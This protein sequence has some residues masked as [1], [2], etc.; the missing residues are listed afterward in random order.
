MDRV[1]AG[2]LA[3]FEDV[4]RHPG[5][6]IREVTDRTGLAQSL[7]SRIV[8]AAAAAG[9]L[10]VTTDDRDR[11]RVR[12]ELSSTASAA[13]LQ[14]ADEPLDSALEQNTPHLTDQERAALH[15]HLAAAAE[16]LSRGAR[17]N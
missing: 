3:V 1:N 15:R 2:Q 9:A 8:G 4:A 16:L 5:A 7:V 13:I 10:T 6:S 12:I 14:R 17:V 11:R